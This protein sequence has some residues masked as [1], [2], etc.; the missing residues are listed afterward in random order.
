MG[1][2]PTAATFTT[3]A[4]GN[5]TASVS[6][7]SRSQGDVT[8]TCT[9][10]G[11]NI[12][13]TMVWVRDGQ[14]YIDRSALRF[15]PEEPGKPRLFAHPAMDPHYD[16]KPSMISE[17]TWNRPNHT[18]RCAVSHF[19]PDAWDNEVVPDHEELARKPVDA[20]SR[21]HRHSCG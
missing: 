11:P 9:R 14:T 19:R 2:A 5:T 3:D 4:A 10:S 15:D 16:G 18:E 1:F 7:S 8:I 12:T 21:S 13:G 20:P 6:M 17:T